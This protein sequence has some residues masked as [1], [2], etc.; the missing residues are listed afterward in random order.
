M[1]TVVDRLD[2]WWREAHTRKDLNFGNMFM[3]FALV[4]SSLSIILQ[5]PSPSSALVGM[6]DTLQL[7]M[8]GCIY[9]GCAIKLHGALS[10]RRWYF[11]RTN[12]KRCYAYGYI[13]A[14]MATLGS[15]VYG[16]FILSNTETPLS[17]MGGLATPL[18][19]IGIS[20]QAGLYWL[21]NRRLERNEGIIERRAD[22]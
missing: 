11:P 22:P 5:G 15:L 18:F 10:G 19:G 14:P 9:G 12:L 13:G 21:E 3:L 16:W 1:S 2:A 6:S 4:F 17:A 7:S 20:L 8:C